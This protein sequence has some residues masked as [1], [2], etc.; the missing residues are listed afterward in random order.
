MSRRLLIVLAGVIATGLVAPAGL[1][2]SGR[3][4]SARAVK[5][6]AGKV[7]LIDPGHNVRSR[8]HPAEIN[9]PVFYGI[10]GATKPCDTRT[11]SLAIS[12][13]A[14]E[15]KP[16]G[17]YHNIYYFACEAPGVPDGVSFDGAGLMGV[18]RPPQAR[19]NE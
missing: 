9:R 18:C 7:I 4:H 19:T 13:M 3:T 1:A 6:L 15:T 8:L 11:L 2:T 10:P 5:S 16:I 12:L 17:L 14:N